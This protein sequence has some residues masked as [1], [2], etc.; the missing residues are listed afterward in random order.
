MRKV[1]IVFAHP[2]LERSR[3]N[4]RLIEAVAD[5]DGV[6]IHDL[7]DEYPEFDI[8]V[9]REQD[10]LTAHDVVV[11]QH[12]FYW[13]SAPAILKQWQDLVL[14]HGWAYGR[15]GTALR[16]KWCLHAI[17]AGGREESY[18][19]DGGNRFTVGELLAPFEQT[20]QLCGM[21][22]LPPFVVHGTHLLEDAEIAGHAEDY[23][24]VV[25]GLRD[26]LIDVAAA[27]QLPRLNA[28]LAA[29]LGG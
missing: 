14:E 21:C 15:T 20:A 3:V 13:Y 28:N 5:L 24:R 1:L 19:L 29:A 12:P 4:L 22:W 9:R 11:L 6:E 17:T 26:E 23:R 27:R 8:D 2:A 16:E 7:Y 18:R 10:L 25:I